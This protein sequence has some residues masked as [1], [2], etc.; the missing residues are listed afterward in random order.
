M[1]RVQPG[2]KCEQKNRISVWSGSQR[3]YL[4]EFRGKILSLTGQLWSKNLIITAD[5]N[6]GVD[7]PTGFT[8]D[9][10]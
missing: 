5:V 4:S 9:H 6:V 2:L 10:K 8:T 7:R 3:L 1:I